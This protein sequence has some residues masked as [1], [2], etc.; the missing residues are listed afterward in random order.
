MLNTHHKLKFFESH[1]VRHL[2]PVSVFCRCPLEKIYSKFTTNLQ[3]RPDDIDM[4][5]HVHSSRYLDYVLAARFDQMEHCYKMSMQ[6]FMERGLGWVI[7][8]S[9]IEFIRPLQLGDHFSVTTCISKIFDRGV[10]VEFEMNRKDTG[11]LCSKGYLECYLINT[12]SG[13]ATPIP[14]DMKTFYEI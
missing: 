6:M 4:N 7:K 1:E 3:V 9:H 11:K 10:N 12:Q 13:R 8:T 5:Q 14:D 2:L